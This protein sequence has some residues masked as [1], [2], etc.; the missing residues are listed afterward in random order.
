VSRAFS[1]PT[2]VVGTLRQ[3]AS[4]HQTCNAAF[5]TRTGL[6]QIAMQNVSL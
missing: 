2:I 4:P 6:R 5:G 3:T 1:D